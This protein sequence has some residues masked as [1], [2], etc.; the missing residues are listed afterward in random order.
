MPKDTI[1]YSNTIIYK[2]YCKNSNINDVY[3]G[4]TTNMIKRKC[5]HKSGCNN[6]NNKLK[7]YNTIREHGGWENWEMIE[8]AKYNCKDKTEA[9]IKEQQ[10]YEELKS[11]LNSCH[12]FVN[13]NKYYCNSCKMQCSNSYQYDIHLK[14]K[15]HEQNLVTQGDIKTPKNA[16]NYVCEVCDFKCS[17][18]SDWTRHTMRPK[19]KKLTLGDN[20]GDNSTFVHTKKYTCSICNKGYDSRNGLWKHNK[21]C[22]ME[23]DEEKNDPL[24]IK[25]I[26]SPDF[27]PELI[28]LITELVKGQNGI[29]ESIVELCKNGTTNTNHS[30]NTTTNSHNKSFNLQFFLNETCKDAMNITDFVDSLQLQ[31]SDLENVGDV[32]YIEGISNIIIKNL[33]ALDVTERPIHCTDKKRETMYIK[34]EDKWEK[35]DEKRVKMHKMVKKVANKNINL[36]SEFQKVHPEYKKS[37]SRVS[38]KYNKIVIESMGGTGDND[39][40]KEEKIIKRVAKEVFVEKCL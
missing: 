12:P 15:K 16:A 5:L 8:I 9:R 38:D 17:K 27:T 13:I 6:L 24:T 4:H 22:K 34:D 29:Q 40:E 18:V 3:I 25:Q 14:C 11:S 19:H 1:D 21:K 33:N 28:K 7:I 39:Y 2:I 10:H 35:E 36:I 23:Q 32:G 31:L 20:L 37:S 26:L 30:H